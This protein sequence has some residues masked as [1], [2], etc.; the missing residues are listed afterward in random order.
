MPQVLAALFVGAGVYSALKWIS[1]QL[2][3]HAE[4]VQ[5]H[6]ASAADGPKDLGSLEFDPDAKV[7]RP[8]ARR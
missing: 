1:K 6:A 3:A 8:V 4:A 7:Y 5:R 2:V